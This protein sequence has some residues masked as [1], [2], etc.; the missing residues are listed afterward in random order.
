MTGTY[1]QYLE[2]VA[3][4][5]DS[6]YYQFYIRDLPIAGFPNWKWLKNKK[7]PLLS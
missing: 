2:D 5:S 3:W 4:A 6:K 7:M 1:K